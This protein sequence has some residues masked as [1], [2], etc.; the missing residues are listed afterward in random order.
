MRGK[1]RLYN[2]KMDNRPSKGGSEKARIKKALET[3]AAKFA[4]V[5]NFFI[6][7]RSRFE[8]EMPNENDETGKLS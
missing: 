4:K 2:I 8:S 6:E 3:D 1:S 5:S 7:T